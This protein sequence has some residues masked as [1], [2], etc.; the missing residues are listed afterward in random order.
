[1]YF[2][3][4]LACIAASVVVHA[5]IVQAM[6]AMPAQQAPQRPKILEVRVIQPPPEEPE[7]EPPPPE[8]EEKPKEPPPKPVLG[9]PKVPLQKPKTPQK[10]VPVD[11]PPKEVPPSEREPVPGAATT[12]TPTFGFSLESTSEA[13]TGP[14]MPVGNSLM[15]PPDTKQEVPKGP[16]K[17]LAKPVAA[18]EVT[19]MPEMAERCPGQYTDAAKE[20]GIEG[21]VLL[22]LVV[23]EEGR[24]T[25]I[26][27]VQGLGHGLDEAAVKTLERC[28]FKPG[29]RGGK[30]VAVRVRGF[31]V[32][33]FLDD[34]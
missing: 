20:A 26:R 15:V 27:V 16:V 13:G 3:R 25:Q 34:R 11:Q 7:P 12:D 21:V 17:P 33:F 19:K 14:A 31:K 4:L 23:D 10:Q 22:D 29:E 18:D 32:R 28:R 5:L 8:P 6:A 24:A 30:A 2:W 9:P 1:V